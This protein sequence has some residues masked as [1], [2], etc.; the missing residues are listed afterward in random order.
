MVAPFPTHGWEPL[1]WSKDGRDWQRSATAASIAE[2]VTRD[3][4]GG[5]VILL[6]DAD[7]YAA[8]ES[9]RQKLAALPRILE[10]IDDRRLRP[11]R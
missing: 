11:A 6:D 7:H 2:R 4:H 5:V 1:P 3:L 8:P 9:W 10:A